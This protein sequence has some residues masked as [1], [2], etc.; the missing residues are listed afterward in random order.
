ML[1]PF[2]ADCRGNGYR[3]CVPLSYSSYTA[4]AMMYPFVV[5]RSA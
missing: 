1:R 5:D 4:H 2:T 3:T